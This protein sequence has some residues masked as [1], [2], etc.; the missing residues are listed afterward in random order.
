L[1]ASARLAISAPSLGGVDTLIMRPA[2][3]SHR[4]LTR[5]ERE[6][7]GIGD[8]LVRFSVG[9]ETPDDLINDLEQ[10]LRADL[11]QCRRSG[12]ESAILATFDELVTDCHRPDNNALM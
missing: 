7:I 8:G 9:L 3:V 4:N 6:R 11:Y 12:S 10:A 1:A 5:Q 2:V